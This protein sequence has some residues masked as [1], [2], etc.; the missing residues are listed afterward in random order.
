MMVHSRQ[1]SSRPRVGVRQYDHGDLL[2]Q[3]GF[4]HLKSVNGGLS[5]WS[6][7]IDRNVPRY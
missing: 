7:D 4:K 5:A 1:T 3:Q 2:P 6:D